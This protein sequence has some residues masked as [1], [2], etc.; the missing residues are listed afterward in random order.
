MLSSW[1]VTKLHKL[2]SEGN[3]IRKVADI[4]ITSRATVKKHIDNPEEKGL[5]KISV[6]ERAELLRGW[7]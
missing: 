7:R 1:Q 6:I 3:S 4:L 5:P 2:I